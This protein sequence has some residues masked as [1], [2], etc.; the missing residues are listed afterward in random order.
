MNLKDFLRHDLIGLKMEVIESKNM[1]LIGIIGTII[2]ETKHTLIIKEGNKNKT[3]IKNQVTLKIFHNQEEIKVN[4]EL[5]VGRP[6]DRL[7]R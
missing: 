6:E 4:C 3:L 2:D 7:K 5:L 1:K